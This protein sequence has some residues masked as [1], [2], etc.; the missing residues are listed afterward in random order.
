MVT[1]VLADR[2]RCIGSGNCAR[3]APASFDQDDDGL[4]VLLA[5]GPG[6]EAGPVHQAV[7]TCPVK[8]LS[9]SEEGSG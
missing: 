6:P 2:E 1:R 9:V 7:R 4:V 5:S 8:A 3:L